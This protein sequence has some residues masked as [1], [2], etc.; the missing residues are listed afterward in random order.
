[1]V[2][3]IITLLIITLSNSLYPQINYVALGED[4]TIDFILRY[5]VLDEETHMPIK[6]AQ[7][8]LHGNY[9]NYFPKK[10][11]SI[12]TSKNGIGIVL[13]KTVGYF[14]N[15]NMEIKAKKYNYWEDEI[16]QLDYINPVGKQLFAHFDDERVNQW[17]YHNGNI[18]DL[19]LVNA[20]EDGYYQKVYVPTGFPIYEKTIYLKKIEGINIY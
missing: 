20:L 19:Q 1:M 3:I 14:P 12:R 7:I 8:T 13:V 6:N 9:G 5:E 17:D 2:K 15:G 16:L 18:T 4:W 10:V 11:F